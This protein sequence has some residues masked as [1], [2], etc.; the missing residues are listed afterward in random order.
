[1][2]LLDAML[3]RRRATSLEQPVSSLRWR[4]SAASTHLGAV[5]G[6]WKDLQAILERFWATRLRLE[7]VAPDALPRISLETSTPPGDQTELQARATV[8]PAHPSTV[9]A[10]TPDVDSLAAMSRILDSDQEPPILVIRAALAAQGATS[11][12]ALTNL[13]EASRSRISTIIVQAPRG[14][15]RIVDDAMM[16]FPE[17]WRLLHVLVAAS[18]AL[19]CKI[20]EVQ[21]PQNGVANLNLPVT[22][23]AFS[24]PAHPIDP[25]LTSGLTHLLS[26]MAGSD[27][28]IRNPLVADTPSEIV[29]DL[30]AR[31][32]RRLDMDIDSICGL[33]ENDNTYAKRV[34]HNV[35][36]LGAL[37]AGS[38]LTE[39]YERMLMSDLLRPTNQGLADTY[40]RSIRELPAMSDRDVLSHLNENA[41]GLDAGRDRRALAVGLL[42]RHAESVRY[43]LARAMQRYAHDIVAGTLA[44]TCLLMRA[45]L[46]GDLRPEA[47]RAR[48][49]MFRKLGKVPDCWEIWFE[50]GE[51]LYLK[52]SKG[53]DYIHVLLQS[54]G[55]TFSP[56]E[57][58]DAIAGHGRMPT[59]NLGPVA[60][61]QAIRGYR[62]RLAE[63]RED[64]DIATEN[65][66]IGRSER[67]MYEIDA[68]EQ[69]ISR[70]VGLGGRLRQNTDAE[71][72]RKSVSNAIYRA[73]NQLRTRH[74]ALSRH[75]STTLKIGNGVSYLPTG[76][77]EWDT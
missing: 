5:P 42:R 9:V 54:P 23:A 20:D 1:M 56:A 52:G 12:E 26:R 35:S 55:S 57:L 11:R 21:V 48:K 38:S 76:D 34:D 13:L 63:L 59:G 19:S 46:P 8:A 60:D 70:C 2:S 68:L 7:L 45:T 37:H 65:N 69:E 15:E 43:V 47:G 75:L 40:V 17:D 53:L 29:A 44:S 61:T 27:I 49:P 30:I 72:A 51:P 77:S 3:H 14:Q 33:V 50:E 39:Q 4:A 31:G 36:I 41:A 6:Y 32:P 64:L 25:E 66:D 28:K 73:L 16:A 58:R 74:P 10:F 67:I 71:R 24:R 62:H 22:A 18:V